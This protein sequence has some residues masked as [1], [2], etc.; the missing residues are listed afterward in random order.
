M[1]KG[2]MSF[3][4][5]KARAR[6]LKAASILS[7]NW[8]LSRSLR[9]GRVSY[10][11]ESLR[12]LL[13]TSRFCIRYNVPE[14]PDV[15]E[16]TASLY[17][18]RSIIAEF[19]LRQCVPDSEEL[20]DDQVHVPAVLNDH[21]PDLDSAVAAKSVWRL[22]LSLTHQSFHA[23]NLFNYR[24]F[25]DQTASM[26]VIRSYFH[27]Q[28]T[29]TL[30]LLGFAVR[31]FINDIWERMGTDL[32][33]SPLNQWYPRHPTSHFIEVEEYATAKQ[34]P[35]VERKTKI[36]FNC[37]SEYVTTL[38]FGLIYEHEHHVQKVRY[39]EAVSLEL[40]LITI[41][42]A[43]NRRYVA[44]LSLPAEQQ[45]DL[46][47]GDALTIDFN[48]DAEYADPDSFWHATVTDPTSITPPGMTTLLLTRP[49]S[50]ESGWHELA[51]GLEPTPIPVEDLRDIADALHTIQNHAPRMVSVRVIDSD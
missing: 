31:H 24:T 4:I 11:S 7:P 9:F 21:L 49:W 16:D 13:T 17:L 44:F 35:V 46:R 5:G 51:D 3:V 8:A 26:D 40:R 2:L 10:L 39:I 29:I 43:G 27:D 37:H 1:K 6:G 42:R 30:F 14:D 47:S 20:Q 50:A 18:T 32:V 48:P 12:C 19:N 45:L 34:R 36:S 28:E 15:Q 38:G 33:E 23:S 22:D 41:P 25:G